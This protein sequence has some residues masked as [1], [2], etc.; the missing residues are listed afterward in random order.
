MIREYMAAAMKHAH[1]EILSD[2][3]TY[4]GEISGFEGVYANGPQLEE[5]S[6]LLEEILEEWLVMGIS[7]GQALPTVDGLD[8]AIKESA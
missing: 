7:R 1:Y 8:M 5:C 2:D 3:G 6:D 4:Y